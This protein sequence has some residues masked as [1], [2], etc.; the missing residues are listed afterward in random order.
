MSTIHE[1]TSPLPGTFY[2]RESPS[3]PPYVTVG[4]RVVAGDTVGVV[5]VMKMFNPITADVTGTVIEIC[6]GDEEPVDVGE[7]LLKVAME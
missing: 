6:V 5:E 2:H 7:V 3:S 4:S 1:V